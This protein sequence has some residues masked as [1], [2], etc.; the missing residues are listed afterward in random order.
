MVISAT[1]GSTEN[2]GN[3]ISE[4]AMLR[5]PIKERHG[6]PFPGTYPPPDTTRF[7]RLTPDQISKPDISI[8]VTRVKPTINSVYRPNS[9]AKLPTN[10]LNRR[11]FL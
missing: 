2:F 6:I 5:I 9:N 3:Q 7:F 11:P 8:I 10:I 4:Y 1:L